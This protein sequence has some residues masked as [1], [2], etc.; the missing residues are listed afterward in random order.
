MLYFH[1]IISFSATWDLFISFSFV[2]FFCNS[3][4]C[5]FKVSNSSAW[6]FSFSFKDDFSFSTAFNSSENCLWRGLPKSLSVFSGVEKSFSLIF[7]L[8]SLFIL[9]GVKAFFSLPFKLNLPG[10]GGGVAFGILFPSI[11]NLPVICRGVGL[12]LLLS[13]K[14]NLLVTL[15]GDVIGLGNSAPDNDF[16]GK[17]LFSKLRALNTEFEILV[18]AFSEV[19]CSSLPALFSVLASIVAFSLSTK[20]SK[21]LT[22][23][24][25]ASR[26]SMG[27]LPHL[28]FESIESGKEEMRMRI[29]SCDAPQIHA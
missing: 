2:S 22:G 3:S 27:V 24:L 17:S 18:L 16:S 10:F 25:V 29:T 11:L 20:S 13:V 8:K 19:S 7:K 12:V 4:H 23:W 14:L 5:A 6:I 26:A 1:S 15:C 28:S 9:V 21:S